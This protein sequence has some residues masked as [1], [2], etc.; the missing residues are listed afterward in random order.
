MDKK[1]G[2]TKQYVQEYVGA[3]SFQ[4]GEDYEVNR[5]VSQGKFKHQ[6][7]TALCQGHEFDPYRV[8]I[9]LGDK[10]IRQS[11][12][13]CP[14]GAGGKCK[15]VAAVLLT[16]IDEP[17]AFMDWQM[18]ESK[19]EKYDA[20]T[21]LELID[22]LEERVHDSAQVIQ[23]FDQN[24]Q[25]AK[26]PHLAKYLKRVEEAFRI[27]RFPWYHPDEGGLAE[28]AFDLEKIRKDAD[29]LFTEGEASDAIQI[30]ESI[31]Q[32]ILGY[33]DDHVDLWGI[34]SNEIKESIRSIEQGLANLPYPSEWR[35]K[36]FQLLFRVIEE[37]IYRDNNIGAEEAKEVILKHLHP[38]EKPKML[39]WVQG[40][41]ATHANQPGEFP[42][43]DDFLIE[44]QKDQLEPE[45]YL[46]H[47]QQTFQ[48][49]KLIDSLLELGRIQEAKQMAYQ[50][51][52]IPQA[53][54]FANLFIKHQQES[55]A[56]DLVLTVIKKDKH[57]QAVQ[58]LKDFYQKRHQGDKAL[59][60]AQQV[61]RLS[62]E[63]ATYQ[64]MQES[65]QTQNQWE[66]VRREA[67][68]FLEREQQYP[69][70]VEIYLD[71]KDLKQAIQAFNHI[72]SRVEGEERDL[73]REILALRL[74]AAARHKHP[75]FAIRI[76]QE[77]IQNLIEERNREG[78][79]RACH[80]M[81]LVYTIYRDTHNLK[82][83][84][85]YLRQIIQMYNRLKAL[86]DEMRQ[87][88]LIF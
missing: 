84:E 86:K 15:H 26:F 25:E 23:S 52:F 66:P 47:Y 38:D 31:I 12:C 78:Y 62:P 55:I 61:F 76:Y 42:W 4:K 74:A 28:I 69:L 44:L 64:D 63:F 59:E 41:Q 24:L 83:W 19:L 17:D 5:T 60:Y 3:A 56:E 79:R 14:V 10:G 87:A 68:A 22:L 20:K 53:V 39:A 36:I 7:L 80:Y 37:Q 50:K 48:F 75:Q 18:I 13:S 30:Y 88:G 77:I 73:G 58:W 71:E 81:N 49:N 65:A 54:A 34:L 82:G 29:Q 57:L 1:F 40:I 33:L 2:L 6:L 72:P 27:S 16:W 35:Q 46:S 70:L 51:E 8:E 11:Y 32:H 85:N 67:L 45:V 43:I 21:L 9:I